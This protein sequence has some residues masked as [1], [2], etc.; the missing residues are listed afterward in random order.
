MCC[1]IIAIV[2]IVLMNY[3]FG[4]VWDRKQT[5]LLALLVVLVTATFI[6]AFKDKKTEKPKG[7]PNNK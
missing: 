7:E 5:C 3:S 2:L 1:G 4:W 6:T